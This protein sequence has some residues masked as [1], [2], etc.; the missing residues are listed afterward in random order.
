MVFISV[1]QKE[2]FLFDFGIPVL[3]SEDLEFKIDGF[4]KSRDGYRGYR[5][6]LS[7]T[8]GVVDTKNNIDF[9][10]VANDIKQATL[11][12]KV[13]NDDDCREPRGEISHENTSSKNESTAYLGKHYVECYAILNNTC[14][15]KSRADVIIRN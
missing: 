6:R 10:V 1:S 13:K 15:A 4:I 12:W 2:K 8:N 14:V 5:A 3:E 7:Q 9:R 11:K